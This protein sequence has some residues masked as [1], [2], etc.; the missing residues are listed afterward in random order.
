MSK[1]F[2]VRHG[3]IKLN[4]VRRFWGKT[5]IELS[6][7]GVRQAKAVRD[8]I[9]EQKIDAVYTST[10]KRTCATAEIIAAKHNLVITACPELNELNFGYVEG[11]TFDEIKRRYPE[12][13]KVLNDWNSRPEFPGGE[14]FDELNTRVQK[15]LARLK[16]HKPDEKILIVAH[17]GSL[18]LIICNLLG[19]STQHWKQ[20]Q[21]DFA[22][23]SIVETFPRGSILSLL[24]DVSHL[25]S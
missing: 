3:S 20:M 15:F 24:N 17:A 1:L 9:S 5:D 14:S 6:D 12:L 16:V 11:L 10:L 7:E 18:R 21:I 19:I 8:R 2:L 22:S 4:D 23:L 13:A 25:K